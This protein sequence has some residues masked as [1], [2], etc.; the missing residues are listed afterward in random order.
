MQ[1]KN[2]FEKSSNITIVAQLIY[3]IY[4]KKTSLHYHDYGGVK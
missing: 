4:I 2:C 1:Q 3:S